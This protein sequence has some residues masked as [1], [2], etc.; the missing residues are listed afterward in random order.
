M[1]KIYGKPS[2]PFCTQ[3][4]QLAEQQ[5]LDHVYLTLDV[6]YTREDLM[7][8]VPNA[9]TVP[10]IFVNE[11]LIGGYNEFETFVKQNGV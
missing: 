7:Q 4:K 6:D 3:A 1:I 2:C 10:Q 5:G 8:L 9:R 11:S